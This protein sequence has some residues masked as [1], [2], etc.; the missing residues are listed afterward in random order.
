VGIALGFSLRPSAVEED[1]ITTAP[2]TTNTEMFPP[3]SSPTIFTT[4]R[5]G[6]LYDA[7]APIVAVDNPDILRDPTTT[8]FITLDWLANA[9]TWLKEGEEDN[10]D[11]DG[12]LQRA[13]LFMWVELYVLAVLWFET[14]TPEE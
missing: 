12:F 5:F 10:D 13:P 6:I 4:K 7:L 8:Q 1:D 11:S 2:T 14:T 3:T 9:D